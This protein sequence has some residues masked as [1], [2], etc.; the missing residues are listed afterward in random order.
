[1]AA[2][3]T[4]KKVK[5]RSLA[6]SPLENHFFLSIGYGNFVAIQKV[7]AILG[8]GSSPLKRIIH[9]AQKKGTLLDATEGRRTRSVIALY[10]VS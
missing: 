1:M 5:K 2:K 10:N 9:E 3:K 7:L 8:A 4:V 6:L